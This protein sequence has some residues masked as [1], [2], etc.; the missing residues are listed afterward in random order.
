MFNALSIACLILNII[1]SMIYIKNPERIKSF[2][3]PIWFIT[4]V[5]WVITMVIHYVK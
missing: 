2:M 5:L 1:N 3:F 4:M